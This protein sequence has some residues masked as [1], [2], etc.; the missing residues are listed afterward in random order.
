MIGKCT[1]VSVAEYAAQKGLIPYQIQG[2]PEGFSFVE[3]GVTIGKEFHQGNYVIFIP[4]SKW[5][6]MKVPFS[7]WDNDSL[8]KYNKLVKSR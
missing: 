1:R 3:E 6:I 8:K 2:I 7:E 4:L 5:S